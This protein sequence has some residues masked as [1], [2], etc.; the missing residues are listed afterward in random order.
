MITSFSKIDFG[1]LDL[2]FHIKDRTKYTCNLVL[3][4]IFQVKHEEIL[5]PNIEIRVYFDG[6]MAEVRNLVN[7]CSYLEIMKF[8]NS[9]FNHMDERWRRNMILNKWLDYLVDLG[10]INTKLEKINL[11]L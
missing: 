6:K 10:H 8:N 2:F 3:S 11:A 4:H 7:S 5:E 9:N 1:D